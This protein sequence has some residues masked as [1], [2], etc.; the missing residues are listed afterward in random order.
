MKDVIK[1][2]EDEITMTKN[3]YLEAE[4]KLIDSVKDYI[5]GI[6]IS[7]N[8][9]GEGQV[10]SYS[11]TTMDNLIID[12]K[13]PTCN[14]RFSLLAII[15]LS[16]SATTFTKITDEDTLACLIK[17]LEVHTQLLKSYK[18]YEIQARQLEAEAQK[19]ALAEQKAEARYQR[20][21]EL[22]QQTFDQLVANAGST[23]SETDDFYYAL[24]WLANHVGAM[25]AV[26]PDYLGSAFEKH[27]GTEAP[28]TLVDGRAKTSG[29]YAKQWSWE[30]K[31]TIKKLKETVVPPCIQSVT[32]DFS[33]GIH[34]TAFL[35]DLVANHGFQFGKKQDVDKIRDTVPVQYITAFNEGLGA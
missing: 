15:N 17:A 19:K 14:K 4:D 28:K 32:T 1:F 31:C 33:K 22:A 9:Y 30:F 10:V 23:W 24:G 16:R 29:G 7:N 3:I 26:L 11:G 20:Q 21:K 12:I 6:N 35:W 27:F 8:V 18:A 34:N 5:V 13:F 25:T 2:L